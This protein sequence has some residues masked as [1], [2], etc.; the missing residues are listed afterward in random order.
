[1]TMSRR[2]VALATAMTVALILGADRQ[3]TLLASPASTLFVAPDATTPCSFPLSGNLRECAGILSRD[4]IAN[5]RSADLRFAVRDAQ[6][7]GLDTQREGEC[8]NSGT[9]GHCPVTQSATPFVNPDSRW[10]SVESLPAHYAIVLGA[11]RF[12][13]GV[14]HKDRYYAKLGAN[15]PADAESR[16]H[17]IV[18]Y[19]VSPKVVT[20]SRDTIIGAWAIYRM[21]KSSDQYADS[22]MSGNLIKCGHP[23]DNPT[24]AE[25]RFTTCVGQHGIQ[26]SARL[27]NTTS[28]AVYNSLACEASQLPFSTVAEPDLWGECGKQRMV[29]V[30]TLLKGRVDSAGAAAASGSVKGRLAFTAASIMQ[31]LQRA[32]PAIDPYW[33]SCANGCC[34]AE[35]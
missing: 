9:T 24:A 26:T 11:M 22:L 17:Y 7:P 20:A 19:A 3:S 8:G 27:L 1:M 34:T 4:F 29:K 18:A 23:P 13:Y 30:A 25:T 6:T 16:M 28:E 5:P 35:L 2:T 21:A 12:K 31:L 14:N 32:Q 15:L 33:F 10:F